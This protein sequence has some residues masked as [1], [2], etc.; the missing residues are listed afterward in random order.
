M[1]FNNIKG[2]IFYNYNLSK[3]T[4]FQVAGNGD[5][6]FFPY[7]FDDLK[8]FLTQINNIP[9]TII[10]SGSNLIIRDGGIKGIVII[11]NNKNFKNIEL[12]NNFIEVGCGC[13]NY[14][15]YNFTKNNEIDDF[16]FLGTIPGTIGGAISGNVGCYGMEIKDILYSVETLDYNGKEHIFYNKDC[17]F[18]YRKN[19]LSNNLIFLKATFEIKNK[20]NKENIENKFKEMIN[21]RIQS[22]P[23]GVK[24]CGST[25]KNPIEKP[26]WRIIQEL[27]YQN[28]NFNGAKMSEKHANFMI[29]ENSTANNLE[30][31]GNQIIKDAKEKLNINLEWEIKILGER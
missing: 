3:Y 18:E 2:E 29:N 6:V 7:D 21:K 23:Q 5:I 14:T 22:Q 9:I 13:L 11:L 26:A 24:T 17:S 4:F 20:N 31:L 12:K 25:F 28:K 15:L 8:N 1:N 27:G 19:N 10:G 30:D 16:E